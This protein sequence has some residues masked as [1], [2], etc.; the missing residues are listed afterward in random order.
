MVLTIPPIKEEIVETPRALPA[1]PCSQSGYPSRTVADAEGVPG[2]FSRIADIEPPYIPPQN[3]PQS[4]TNAVFAGKRY[5]SGSSRM[6]PIDAVR[7][8]SAPMI[9]PIAT[10]KTIN[11]KVR[12]SNTSAKPVNKSTTPPSP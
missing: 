9:T 1:L 6:I 8:G 5:T 2:V 4:M 7:P 3:K 12:G 11:A 10:P